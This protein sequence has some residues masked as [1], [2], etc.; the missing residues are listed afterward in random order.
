MKEICCVMKAECISKRSQVN[1]K[2]MKERLRE[3]W[4]EMER[5]EEKCS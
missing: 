3:E 5:D 1:E 2:E 4:E